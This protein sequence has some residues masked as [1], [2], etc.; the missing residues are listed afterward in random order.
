MLMVG[1][2]VRLN[3]EEFFVFQI[4]DNTPVQFQKEIHL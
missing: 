3:S 1:L 4:I 2:E